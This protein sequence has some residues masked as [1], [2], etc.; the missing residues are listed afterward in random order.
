MTKMCSGRWGSKATSLSSHARCPVVGRCWAA[1]EGVRRSG[2]DA[3]PPTSAHSGAATQ[4]AEEAGWQQMERGSP[5][6]LLHQ[7]E[8]RR[9]AGCRGEAGRQQMHGVGE[10][11][12]M[13]ASEV[14]RVSG[15]APPRLLR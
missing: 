10:P 7:R 11:R 9:W 4:G 12:R 2:S 1:A 13:A 8:R 3:S 6:E 14:K 15:M 5:V